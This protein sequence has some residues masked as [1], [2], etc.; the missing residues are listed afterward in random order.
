MSRNIRASL[1]FLVGFGIA[2]LALHGLS[3]LDRELSGLGDGSGGP[4]NTAGTFNEVFAMLICSYFLVS[5]IGLLIAKTRA[6][7]LLVAVVSHSF[8]VIAYL[9]V[10]C[11]GQGGSTFDFL[12]LLVSFVF[13]IFFAPWVGVWYE[14]L[15]KTK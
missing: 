11:Q 13:L 2:V 4:S 10:C 7:L 15:R 9:M 6:A 3:A 8:V 5:A 1:L 12:I 14:I